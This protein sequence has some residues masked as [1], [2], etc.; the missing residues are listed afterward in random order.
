MAP[1]QSHVRLEAGDQ[2]EEE[3]ADHR[4]RLEQ[5]PKDVKARREW[6]KKDRANTPNAAVRAAL[7][8]WYGKEAAAKVQQAEAFEICE[9]G[10][11]PSQ[12][13]IKRLFPFLP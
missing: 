1:D 4:H 9:Y 7:E 5:V 10:A 13:D 3:R 11:R 8:K 6:L 2:Q 12:A